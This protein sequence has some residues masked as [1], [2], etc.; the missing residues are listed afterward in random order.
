MERARKGRVWTDEEK[1]AF[2]IKMKALRE[3]R[4]AE[5]EK[6]ERLTVVTTAP[7]EPTSEPEQPEPVPVVA[8]NEPTVTNAPEQSMEVILKQA[9][10]AIATLAS[11]TGQKD[12]PAG[13]NSAGKLTGTIEKYSLDAN[14]YPDPRERLANEPRLQRFGF[15]EN[16]DLRYEISVSEYTTIDNIR[17]REPKFIL[18]LVRVLFDE[19]TGIPTGG[20]YV[21][22]RIVMH[23]DPD[24][25]LTVARQNGVNVDDYDER[26]FLNEMRYLQMRDWLF[27]N[28]YKPKSTAINNRREMVIDGKIVDYFEVNSEDAAKIPFSQLETKL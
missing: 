10:E 13:I 6:A 1:K 24:S 17:F 12:S 16:Y 3:K 18:D 9:L 26:S 5:Q 8:V 23:E 28:F 14:R 15:K 2:G 27:E 7:V 11:L 20:R 19:E 22:S 4:L 21:Q 25:A